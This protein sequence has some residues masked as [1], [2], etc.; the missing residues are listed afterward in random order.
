MPLAA[1][2]AAMGN[3]VRDAQFAWFVAIFVLR[4]GA[5]MSVSM[6]QSIANLH[7]KIKYCDVSSGYH[8]YIFAALESGG[9]RNAPFRR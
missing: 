3:L 2:G 1:R 5:G 4:R 8:R 9:W 6:L 7:E